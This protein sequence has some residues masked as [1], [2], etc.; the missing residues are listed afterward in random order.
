MQRKDLITAI[1]AV[2]VVVAAALA[3]IGPWGGNPAPDV[4]LRDLDGNEV[5]LSEFRGQPVLMQFWATTCVTCVAEMPHLV[6]L[7]R[8]LEPEGLELIGVAMAYDPPA[9]V[10]QMTQEKGLPYR[11]ALDQDGVIAAA[12][13]DVRL[14]PTSVLIDPEGQVAWRRM[15]EIDFEQLAE[16][17]RGMLGEA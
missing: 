6:E 16:R 12:F 15:G 5:N 17:I 3:W 9:Q 4:A 10:R 8:E 7:Y 2:A 14:T 1:A 13:G 11:I